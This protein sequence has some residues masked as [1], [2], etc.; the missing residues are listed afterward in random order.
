[1]IKGTKLFNDDEGFTDITV[2]GGTINGRIQFTCFAMSMGFKMGT[3]QQYALGSRFRMIRLNIKEEDAKAI[4]KR[5]L[6]FRF[7]DRKQ[8]V[9]NVIVRKETWVEYFDCIYDILERESLFPPRDMLGYVN[10]SIHDELKDIIGD[11]IIK[12]P[13][14][15]YIIDDSKSLKDNY[16]NVLR[17]IGMYC[18]DVLT[19]T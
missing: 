9:D 13:Q 8:T 17:Q 15:S 14:R 4:V 19:V 12:N 18:K 10:R 3:K 7:I 16:E 1:M 11:M 5:L 2:E 6:N